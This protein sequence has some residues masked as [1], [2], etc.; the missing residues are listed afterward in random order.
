MGIVAEVPD[1]EMHV[2]C[3]LASG[4]DR[5]GMR[6]PQ[7]ILVH[8]EKPKLSGLERDGLRHGLELEMH[9]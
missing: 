7:S 3:G 8:S 9:G 2:A 6:F 5:E 1:Y 4:G